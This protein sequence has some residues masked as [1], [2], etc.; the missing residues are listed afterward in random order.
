M[1]QTA[2]IHVLWTLNSTAII[3]FRLLKTSPNK[4]KFLQSYFSSQNVTIVGSEAVT[5][6]TKIP[7]AKSRPKNAKFKSFPKSGFNIITKF[8][9]IPFR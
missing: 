5:S 9:M 6:E 8:K 2:A 4:L 1:N 7:I 3:S